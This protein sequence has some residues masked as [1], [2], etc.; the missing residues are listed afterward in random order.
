M[1]TNETARL[2]AWLMQHGHSAEEAIECIRY[3]AG[4]PPK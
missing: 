1:S 2:V 4:I 3:I